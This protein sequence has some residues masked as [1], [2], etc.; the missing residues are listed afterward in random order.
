MCDTHAPRRWH[1][2]TSQDR[3]SA[4]ATDPS[5]INLS[6][7]SVL[8]IS[9]CRPVPCPLKTGYR[10]QSTA[11]VVHNHKWQAKQAVNTQN[12]DKLS[13]LKDTVV[14]IFSFFQCR[15]NSYSRFRDRCYGEL[16]A[17]HIQRNKPTVWSQ[18]VSH[19]QQTESS[20]CDSPWARSSGMF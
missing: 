4:S 13:G 19:F 11:I 5:S 15:Q 20:C 1:S 8:A 7:A 18:W 6:R 2:I 12:E 17:D 10:L 14:I 16:G 9:C 3:S